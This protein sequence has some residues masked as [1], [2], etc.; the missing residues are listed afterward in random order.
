MSL[1]SLLLPLAVIA[2]AVWWF[3]L[4]YG[5]RVLPGPASGPIEVDDA[6]EYARRSLE[7]PGPRH[8]DLARLWGPS[9]AAGVEVLPEGRNFYPRMLEDIAGARHSVHIMQYGFQPGIIGDQFAPLFKAKVAEGVKVR[10]AVD[11]LG[12]HALHR[13][14]Q[15]VQLPRGRGRRGDAPR[16]RAAGSP[17]PRRLAA[18]RAA[19]VADGQGGAPQA[20]PRRRDGRLHRRSRARGPLLRRPLPRRLHPL[21]RTGHAAAPG[22]LPGDL[23]LS[24]RL[25]GRR[26]GS[27]ELLPAGDGGGPASGH[28]PHEL[29]PRVAAADRCRDRDDPHLDAAARHHELLHRRRDA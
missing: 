29:A 8:S 6:M 7:K 11:A 1:R 24:R 5:Q 3:I 26:R 17:G 10:L 19:A 27:R 14:E 22:H 13:V 2:G 28:G 20:R 9:S 4:R 16:P 15:D 25:A 12:S 18:A 21:H 23:R